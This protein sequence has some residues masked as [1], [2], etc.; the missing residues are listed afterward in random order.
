MDLPSTPMSSKLNSVN[1]GSL[2]LMK[3]RNENLVSFIVVGT[4]NSD[5]DSAE[6]QSLAKFAESTFDYYEILVLTAAPTAQWRDVLKQLGVSIPSTRV[7]A[8]DTDMPYEELA[9]IAMDHAIGDYIISVQ[10]GEV[11]IDVVNQIVQHLA[12][13]ECDLVKVVHDSNKTSRFERASTR[14]TNWIT[15]AITGKHIQW[16]QARAYG[17]SRMAVSKISAIDGAGKLFRILDLSGYLQQIT[18]TVDSPL[19]RQFFGRIGEKLR[20]ASEL[21]A[22]SAAR[23][24]RAFA[25]ICL[26]LATLSLMV[27]VISVLIWLIKSDIAQ[28]WTSLVVIFSILFSANFG[29][30]AAICLGLYQVLRSNQPD[31]MEMV[32]TEHSG[33][34]FFQHDS[35]LNIETSAKEN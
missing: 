4:G 2:G 15:L 32:T 29:V 10:P 8:I 12:N 6:V 22:L 16:Y 31:M 17:L 27:T 24:I 26:S 14:L 9:G 18:V 5:R 13:G 19:K 30:L 1:A 3:M 28:G 34:D 33:G 7:I 35:K 11:D 25:I 23:L 21:L 20:L